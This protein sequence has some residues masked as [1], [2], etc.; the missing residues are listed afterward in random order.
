MFH[1]LLNVEPSVG[2]KKDWEKSFEV[3]LEIEKRLKCRNKDRF[4]VKEIRESFTRDKQRK[5]MKLE[6]KEEKIDEKD[7]EK[8]EYR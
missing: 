8:M 5:L 1:H 3:H 2:K 4:N 7:D 6:K